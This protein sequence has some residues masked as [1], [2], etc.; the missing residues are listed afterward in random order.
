MTTPK[1]KLTPQQKALTKELKKKAKAELEAQYRAERE[2]AA[3]AYTAG[4]P[5]R[6][7]EIQARATK[8]SVRNE[9]IL[10]ETGPE[11]TFYNDDIGHYFDT[12]LSYSSDEWEVELLEKDLQ[13]LQDRNDLAEKRRACAQAA[14]NNLE[15]DQKS[16]LREYITW[17]R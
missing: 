9:V 12:T 7:M 5:R 6:L 8:L 3:A 14:W 17:M 15:E 16:C 10:T 2:S 11:V 4:L 13:Q 1:Q